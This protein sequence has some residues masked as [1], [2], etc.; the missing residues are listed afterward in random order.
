MKQILVQVFY[1]DSA[2]YFHE[3]EISLCKRGAHVKFIYFCV[4]PC[5][6]K[7]C[8]LKKLKYIYSADLPKVNIQN[9][10][11]DE[12]ILEI[13][14]FS[15]ETFKYYQKELDLTHVMEYVRKLDACL[16][17]QLK[18]CDKIIVFGDSRLH[19][20]C[21]INAAEFYKIKIIYFEQGPFSTNIFN[22]F[23][24]N[25]NMKIDMNWR[26][27]KSKDKNFPVLNGRVCEHYWATFRNST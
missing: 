1:L 26:S 17:D 5:A 8:Q 20:R 4:Y 2:R 9:D 22:D 23:G 14:N 15:I 6:K 11:R 13:A 18:K 10:N 19:S 21:L 27:F 7:Y 16:K 3:L 24:V 25:A 12:I